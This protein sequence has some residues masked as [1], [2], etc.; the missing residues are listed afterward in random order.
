V[1]GIFHAIVDHPNLSDGIHMDFLGVHWYGSDINH[2]SST[3]GFQAHNTE[4]SPAFGF[5]DPGNVIHSVYLVPIYGEGRR[6]DLLGPSL[7][8]LPSEGNEDFSLYYVNF[9]ADHDLFMWFF[10]GGVG[11]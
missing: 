8:C 5:V 6:A 10:G 11:Q 9:F 1:I 2:T 4:A 3:S 7:A